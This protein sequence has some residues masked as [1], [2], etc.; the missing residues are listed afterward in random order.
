MH[1]TCTFIYGFPCTVPV[2]FSISA[3]QPAIV[4]LPLQKSHDN[5]DQSLISRN[6]PAKW[7]IMLPLI[8]HAYQLYKCTVDV[9]VINIIIIPA[10]TW[11]CIKL[12]IQNYQ[13]LKWYSCTIIIFCGFKV[14]SYPV[15]SSIVTV[16]Y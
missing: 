9:F 2:S 15:C 11:R 4:L 3:C 1:L 13:C 14:F 8:V 5:A 6:M 12:A 7:D 10:K 16:L